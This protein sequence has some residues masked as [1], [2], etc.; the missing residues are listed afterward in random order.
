MVQQK[1]EDKV[2]WVAQESADFAQQLRANPVAFIA[3]AAL[4]PIS[5]VCYFWVGCSE[6]LQ[7][8][9]VRVVSR[10]PARCELF[11]DRPS[12]AS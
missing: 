9:S 8:Q 12:V 7:T 4:E 5:E 3:S 1:N 11:P 10:C 6:R 2:K